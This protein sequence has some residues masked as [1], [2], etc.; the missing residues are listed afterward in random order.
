[1]EKLVNYQRNIFFLPAVMTTSGRIGGDFLRLIYI[2]SHR[3]AANYFT[4]MGLLDPSPRHTNNVEAR[5][6]IT[7]A[8]PSA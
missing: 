3:Q 6:S 1:M 5:T 7:T 8:P 4:R 2:L